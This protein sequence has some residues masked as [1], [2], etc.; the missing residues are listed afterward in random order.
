MENKE[1]GEFTIKIA[2]LEVTICPTYGRQARASAAVDGKSVQ[3]LLFALG[4][5]GVGIAEQ[6][7]F[8]EQLSKP[9]VEHKVIGE[10]LAKLGALKSS[11]V[12]AEVI[13]KLAKGSEDDS[14]SEAPD[15]DAEGK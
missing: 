15:E 11:E 4:R 3:A 14:E 1:R 6:A 9:R 13:T 5:E 10:A 8:I 2:N 7:N 12:F